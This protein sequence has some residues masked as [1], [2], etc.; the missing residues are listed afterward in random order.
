[1]DDTCLRLF[2]IISKKNVKIPKR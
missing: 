2:Y 1:L